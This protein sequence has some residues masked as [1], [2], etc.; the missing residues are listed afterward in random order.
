MVSI[1]LE[2]IRRLSTSSAAAL[3]RLMKV[4]EP[5]LC[6]LLNE[7]RAPYMDWRL[8]TDPRP[9]RIPFEATLAAGPAISIP[10]DVLDMRRPYRILCLDGGGVRGVMTA[11]ILDRI[12]KHDPDFM[13]QVKY[14]MHV[15][16]I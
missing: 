15:P 6:K 14:T 4:A 9:Q 7:K 11:S 8:S 12:V 2:M 16:G 1:G 13:N 5:A 10:Q 3:N